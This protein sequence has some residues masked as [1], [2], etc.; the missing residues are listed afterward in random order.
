MDVKKVDSEEALRCVELIKAGKAFLLDVRTDEEWSAGHAP[1]AIH[2]D[3]A[4][5]EKGE[6]PDLP[7]DA[8]IC[9]C[10]VSGGRAETAKSI[11]L[12]KGFFNVK[13]LGGLRDWKLAGGGV[14]K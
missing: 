3:L 11:L 5:L 8:E 1:M 10:C 6:F 4:R 12:G 14:V 13:N 9:T 2:F 7:R